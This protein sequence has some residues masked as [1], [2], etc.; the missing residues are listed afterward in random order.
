[1]VPVTI[2]IVALLAVLVFSGVPDRLRY[3]FLHDHLD[4]VLTAALRHR[5]EIVTARVPRTPDI[6]IGLKLHAWG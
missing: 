6:V 5:P 2:A 3:T 4:L 1:M